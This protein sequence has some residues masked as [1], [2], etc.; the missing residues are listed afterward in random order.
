MKRKMLLLLIVSILVFFNAC[1]KTQYWVPRDLTPENSFTSGAEGP[2][3]ISPGPLF[4]V[5]Y[6]KNGTIGIVDSLGRAEIFTTL[7]NGSIGNGIRFDKD[8]NMYIADYVNHNILVMRSGEQRV[9]VYAHDSTMN[10]PNDLAITYTGI[11]F[12]S[13]PNW[14][15]GTGNIYRSSR[16]GEIVKIDS[17]M[18]TTNGIEVS[19]GDKYLY[20]NESIQRKIWRYDLDANGN[21]SNK[22]LLIEFPDFGLDGMRCDTLGNLYVC[23]YD[24]G[25]IAIVSPEGKV[26]REV[27]LKGKKVSNIAFGGYDGKTCYV[28]VQD[29]GN[30]EVFRSETP[31]REWTFFQN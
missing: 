28:T 6:E 12:A 8:W 21:I 29:R 24:K 1:R 17:G 15:D 9:V 18:G 27:E 31:G 13:D 25:T 23:R 16:E 11:L 3:E 26:I 5:N 7:P 20:V 14:K 30:V 2:A 19:P 22:T 4:A 10:Q